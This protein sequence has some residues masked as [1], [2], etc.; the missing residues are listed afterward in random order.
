MDAIEINQLKAEREQLL[1][2]FSQFSE[3]TN[4]YMNDL[5]DSSFCVIQNGGKKDESGKTVPRSLRKLPIKDSNG[6]LDKEHVIAAY[7]A[8]QGARGG[9]DL[10][11][12]EKSEA[13]TRVNKARKELGL[14][15]NEKLSTPLE[16][17]EL[18]TFAQPFDEQRLQPEPLPL[19]QPS[20]QPNM[21]ILGLNER[22]IMTLEKADQQLKTLSQ[23]NEKLVNDIHAKEQEL[24]TFKQAEIQSRKAQY[25]NKLDEIHTKWCETF[26]LKEVTQQDEARRMLSTFDS[27][28]KLETIKR[29]LD[30]KTTQMSDVPQ[31]ITRQSEEL[32]Q[33]QKVEKA[34]KPWDLVTMSA[35]EKKVYT[36]QI[37]EKLLRT[38]RK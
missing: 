25:E 20:N 6:K 21:E 34:V 30:V 3:W 15:K 16:T 1:N 7:A 35:E 11:P 24:N 26:S 17:D 10:S 13:L 9:V 18:I 36:D 23:L 37:Y 4:K 12:A 33:P 22:L 5:P 14:I 32:A 31:Q 28:D 2:K 29:F 8:L 38:K 19:I 27:E